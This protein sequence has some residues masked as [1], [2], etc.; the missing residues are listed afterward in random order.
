MFAHTRHSRSKLCRGPVSDSSHHQQ[1]RYLRLL[2]P[3]MSVR[4]EWQNPTPPP[5]PHQLGEVVMAQSSPADRGFISDLAFSKDG[6]R[7]LAASSNGDVYLF[8]S[9]NQ[10]LR[11]ALTDSQ[12]PALKVSFLGGDRNFVTA[13]TDNNIILWDARNTNR[14]VNTLRGHTNL[15]RSLNYDEESG[16][17]LS[18]SYD[19]NVRYWH[20]QSYQR[21]TERE[22]ADS[23]SSANYRGILLTCRDLNQVTV[24][25]SG[26]KLLLITSKGV[27]YAISNFDIEHVKEDIKFY[28]FDDTLPLLLS[29]MIPNSSTNRRNSVRMISSSDYSIDPQLKLSKI[30][31]LTTHPDLPLAMI[32]FNATRHC[33][34]SKSWTSVYRLDHT[35]PVE[36]NMKF[37]SVK[38]YGADIV[39][40][41]LLFTCEETRYRTAFEKKSCFSK[42]GRVIASPEKNGVCLLSFSDKLDSPLSA[43][44]A[45]SASSS[46]GMLGIMGWAS[47]GPMPLVT[48]A[49]I[50]RDVDSVMCTRFSEAAE[51][52]VLAV[53]G[54]EGK[55]SFHQPKL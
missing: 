53:G 46:S 15:V 7:L 44:S 39:E 21:K 34:Q 35:L 18:S 5:P 48:V 40:E 32:R 49:S 29:W 1:W 3:K 14:A 55:V 26:K 17:L 22:D 28:R 2:Y 30:H 19:G 24:S 52:L 20:M 16:K 25:K 37:N 8:D 11:A 23:E 50:G 43:R 51:G 33:S 47:H 41:N 36:D 42:C 4:V 6:R 38:A 31:C 12:H 45:S 10:R 9:G 27:I 54:M 13:S